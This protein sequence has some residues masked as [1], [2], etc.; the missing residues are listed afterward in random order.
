MNF[1]QLFAGLL[2]ILFFYW[3][4]LIFANKDPV[5]VASSCVFA[6]TVFFFLALIFNGLMIGFC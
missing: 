1:F 4:E 3:Q 2:L 6:L 5:S